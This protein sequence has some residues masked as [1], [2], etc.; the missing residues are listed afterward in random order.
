MTG[1]ADAAAAA[2]D[3][4]LDNPI[5]HALTGPHGRF[6]ERRRLALR[7]DPAVTPFAALSDPAD[8]AAWADLADL[9]G[10]G[11]ALP[12]AA[13][14]ST[15][16]TGWHVLRRLDIQQMVDGGRARAGARADSGAVASGDTGSLVPLGPA[17]VPEMLELVRR[18]DPGPFEPRTIELGGFV[19][20][21]VGGR[22]A[23]MAGRRMHPPGW[24]EV[25][26]VC[27]DPAYR[28]QGLGRRVLDAVVGAIQDGG[29]RAFLHV[30]A[31]NTG[32]IRLYLDAGLTRR[33][34]L[35]IVVVRSPA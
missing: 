27:T 35:D 20:V 17:D 7:Y 3:S 5:W 29:E 1:R 23:A 21:R 8:P 19:G 24:V 16:P 14:E 25:T 30:L 32:A 18:T 31:G 12:V 10:P 6:A 22:L 13:P 28:G 15:V 11:A 33:R 26:A 2:G 4:V 9:V 34:T